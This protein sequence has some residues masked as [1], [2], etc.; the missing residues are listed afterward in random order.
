MQLQN[1]RFFQRLHWTSIEALEIR[2]LTHH[3]MEADL[4][5]YQPGLERRPLTLPQALAK[6]VG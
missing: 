3:L 4:S 1:V 5:Y 2:G 6:A